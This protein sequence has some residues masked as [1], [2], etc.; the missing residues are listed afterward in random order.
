MSFESF[1]DFLAM[2]KH[3]AFELN[4]SSDIDPILLFDRDRLP[5]RASATGCSARRLPKPAPLPCPAG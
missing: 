1:S 4:Y 2:G 5:R 3:G